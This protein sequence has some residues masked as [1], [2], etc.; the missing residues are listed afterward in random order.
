MYGEIKS[1]TDQAKADNGMGG[2]FDLP[3]PKFNEEYVRK[4]SNRAS[5]DIVAMAYDEVRAPVYDSLFEMQ[6]M[7]VSE[8][9][10]DGFSEDADV[11]SNYRL[12]HDEVN[13][14]IVEYLK[15]SKGVDNVTD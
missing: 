2:S 4:T 10:R 6:E 5:R 7:I 1:A 12:S 14:I 8:L 13:D 11:M 15:T 3:M 9:R